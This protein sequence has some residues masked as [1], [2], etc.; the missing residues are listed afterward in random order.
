[1]E[2]RSPLSFWRPT[3]MAGLMCLLLAANDIATADDA[4][5]S[6]A[7]VD[8]A[9]LQ[10]LLSTRC[11]KCHGADAREG[12]LRMLS[13]EDF[14]QLND[15]GLPA[16]NGE[17]ADQSELLRRLRAGAN[18]RMP[19]EGEPLSPSEIELVQTWIAAGLPWNDA[20]GEV[21]WA[22]VSPQR[23]EVPSNQQAWGH[24]AVDAFVLETIE[25]EAPDLGPAAPAAPE[26]LLRRVYLDLIG[27]PP[28]PEVVA[29]FVADPSAE[30]YAEIV[31]KLLASPRYGEKWARGW[32][33]LARYADSNGFQADQFREIWPYRDWVIQAMNDDMPFD[34]FTI[35]QIAGDLLPE[36]DPSQHI[37]TGFHRCTTCNVE[38]G[39]DP[40]E[41]RV[42][43]IIDRVNTTGTVWLG[44]TFECAQCHNH[45]YDPF[46]QQ[47]YYQLFAFFNNT[48]LEVELPSSGGV[49]YEVAGP[50][51][52]LPLPENEALTRQQ[53]IAQRDTLQAAHDAR[54]ETLTGEFDA[55]LLEMTAMST[56]STQW[57][58]LEIVDFQSTAGCTSELLD[59]GSLLL[60][61]DVPAK[62]DYTDYG[63]DDSGWHHRLQTRNTHRRLPSRHGPRSR[64][65]RTTQL[66]A[67][68]VRS[69]NLE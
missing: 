19:P 63:R 23:P 25:R 57:H 43:Q 9:P 14:L 56:E 54:V 31:D 67:V 20:V 35:E 61:G 18:E 52:E 10:Q 47:D 2:S 16:I 5:T 38:A 46:T 12:G 64:K 27:L 17:D 39:V 66:R 30:H 69:F 1:M 24:N 59:D 13:R 37:A 28:S 41:N 53:L 44:T 7:Q 8:I 33:D 42:N 60:T 49:Q 29:D 58:T 4:A 26:R 48:P 51:M 50:K 62:A 34:R 21:H 45:K 11:Y 22:Y 55:W 68:R 15:S 6:T 3:H 40:E 36:A 65:R 32:L